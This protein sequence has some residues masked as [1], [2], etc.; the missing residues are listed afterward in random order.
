MADARNLKDLLMIRAA[1]REL[2][3]SVNLNLGSALGFK[4]PTGEGISEEPAVIIFVPRKIDNRWLPASM[5]IP[6]ILHGP[7]GLSCPTDVVEGGQLQDDWNIKIYNAAGNEIASGPEGVRR[8]SELTGEPPLSPDKVSALER[9]HGWSEVMYSGSRLAGFTENMEGYTGT[10][11]C[12]V[13]DR[14]SSKLGILTNQHVADHLNNVLLYPWFNGVHAGKAVR[15]YEYVHDQNRFPDIIDQPNE[16][17]R[18]DC[19]YLELDDEIADHVDHTLYGIGNVGDPLH[20]ELETMEPIGRRVTSVGS[21]RAIQKGKIV[22]FSYEYHDGVDSDY[23]DYLI[24]GDEDL[25][26]EGRQVTR[27]AFSDHGDSGKIIVTDDDKHNVVALLW[28]R[29]QERLRSGKMQENWTYAIDI[30]YVLDLLKVDIA[31]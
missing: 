2:I 23:T 11:G 24:I 30:N 12:F 4:K 6:E 20:L 28:G 26:E 10:A 21:R 17:Y 15:L 29:W 25:N 9:L 7:G 16:Y 8:W 31:P 27:T 22:A 1:N 13:R 18:V 19:A 14:Q 3:D 5:K